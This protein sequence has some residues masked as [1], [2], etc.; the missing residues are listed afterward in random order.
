MPTHRLSEQDLQG[1]A[2]ARQVLLGRVRAKLQGCS[3][4]VVDCAAIRRLSPHEGRPQSSGPSSGSGSSESQPASIDSSADE[5]D[6][7]PED[8][9]LQPARMRCARVVTAIDQVV[10]S[11]M[12]DGAEAAVRGREV[13]PMWLALPQSGA[14]SDDDAAAGEGRDI[15]LL[16][17]SSSELEADAAALRGRARR[18]VADHADEQSARGYIV[19]A[20]KIR[21]ADGDAAVQTVRRDAR[22]N[23]PPQA[24]TPRTLSLQFNVALFSSRSP[25]TTDTLDPGTGLQ[26]STALQSG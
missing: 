5:A 21:I 10:K 3:S 11:A 25:D 19:R 2:A 22:I 13:P 20:I 4:V 8:A 7:A 9:R 14:P 26:S 12:E 16:E 1:A 24:G 6:P 18:L 17:T 15:L 23:G